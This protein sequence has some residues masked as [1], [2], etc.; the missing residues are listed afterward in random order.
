[1]NNLPW[2]LR[3][4]HAFLSMRK[5]GDPID[6][7]PIVQTR[8]EDPRLAAARSV[9]RAEFPKFLSAYAERKPGDYFA[10]KAMIPYGGRHTGGEHMWFNVVTIQEGW[11]IGAA[12]AD[13][14]DVPLKAGECLKFQPED[15]ED[16]M[17]AKPSGEM[18]G[19]FS[20]IALAEI[21]REQRGAK[22]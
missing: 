10:V 19:G 11:I 12:D 14:L 7:V 13:G 9:A 22:G 1:M 5:P 18:I 20:T 21:H 16:W 17:A 2:W 6:K 3:V 8:G 15:I 4:A